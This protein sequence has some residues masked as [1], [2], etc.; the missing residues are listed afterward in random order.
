V[1]LEIGLQKLQIYDTISEPDSLR[2]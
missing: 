1:T 2:K